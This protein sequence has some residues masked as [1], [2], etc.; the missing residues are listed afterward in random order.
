[1]RWCWATRG[2]PVV[3]DASPRLTDCHDANSS[4]RYRQTPGSLIGVKRLSETSTLQMGFLSGGFILAV[5]VQFPAF[6]L[7]WSVE[8]LPETKKRGTKSETTWKL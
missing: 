1:M 4:Y 3:A 8:P 7:A 2:A 6:P 5:V